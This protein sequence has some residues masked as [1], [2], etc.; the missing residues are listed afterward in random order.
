MKRLLA[1][2]AAI[3]AVTVIGAQVRWATLSKVPATTVPTQITTT[4]TEALSITFLG[5]VQPRTNNNATVYIQVIS[6]ATSTGYPLAAGAVWTLPA[7]TVFA[8]YNLTNF[9]LSVP[10][11]NS[12]DGVQVIYTIP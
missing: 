11:T 3:F 12:V 10:T 5:M 9:W 4:S 7:A 1:G 2:L 8:P 6:N